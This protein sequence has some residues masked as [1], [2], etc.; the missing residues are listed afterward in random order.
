MSAEI[1]RPLP[2]TKMPDLRLP[3]VGGGSFELATANPS[4]F[5]LLVFYRGLHC[6]ICK[7]YLNDLDGKLRSFEEAGVLPVAVSCDPKDRAEKTKADWGIE[8]LPIAYDLRV[9]DGRK[10][11]LY[12]SNAIAD[13]EL[14]VFVEPGLFL[15]RPDQ[16]LYAASIQTMPF[17]RP[18]FDEILGAV[19]FVTKNNYP[20]RG[21]A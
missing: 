15:I 2:D 9:E 11:G 5:S 13:R 4:R 3:A 10:W 20:A 6:P 7:G 18:R 14:P 21:T 12:V 8:S 19:Q 1:F 17:A 16:T